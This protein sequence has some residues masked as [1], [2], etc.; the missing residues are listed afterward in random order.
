[1]RDFR[2]TSYAREATSKADD[3]ERRP[4]G[5][6]DRTLVTTETGSLAGFIAGTVVACD[7]GVYQA[8]SGRDRYGLVPMTV[9]L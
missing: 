9:Q 2:G 3:I 8:P 6:G 7:H 4:A 5:W 1:M